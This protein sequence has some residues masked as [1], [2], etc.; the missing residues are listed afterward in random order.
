MKKYK[1]VL[2]IAGSDS[3]GGA[4]IQADIKTISALGCY[5][6][7]VI[8]AITAQNTLGVNAIHPVP[9]NIIEKQLYAVLSDIGTDAVKIGMLHSVEI[10][11]TVSKA[12]IEF[13]VKNIVIDPVMVATSGDKLIED[14]TVDALVNFLFPLADI[15]TPNLPEANILVNYNITTTDQ[16]IESAK[17]LL[18]FGSKSVLLKGGHLKGDILF[19][20]YV[21]KNEKNEVKVFENKRIFTR[22][23]HGTGCTLSSAIASFLACEEKMEIS[24]EK[25]IDYLNKTIQHGKDY[26]TGEGSGPVN[27]FF[28]PKVPE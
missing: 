10:I 26:K 28:N 6:T 25:A 13:Q 11:K 4:G 9:V 23:I 15:I 20:I 5:G 12:L 7:T 27:H 17:K 21:Q 22:N 16:M 18:E 8:T 3:G 14:N 24:V 19:D 1:K 2:T